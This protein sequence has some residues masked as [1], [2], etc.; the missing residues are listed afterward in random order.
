MQEADSRAAQG[1]RSSLEEMKNMASVSDPYIRG[2]LEKRREE[3]TAVIAT[4]TPAVPTAPYLDLLGEVD[5]AIHKMDQG[6]YGI[7]PV[8]HD[9][10]ER[11]RLIA[12]PLVTMC[13]DHLTA[14]DRRALEADLEL[15][16]RVQRGLLPEKHV[17]FGDWHVHYEYKAARMVSGDYCDLILPR[18][19]DGSLLF[20]L[21]DVAGKG[22]AASLLMTHMHAM[23]RSLSNG[24]SGEVLG[25]DKLLETANRVFCESTF[26]G[27]YATLVC[28]CAGGTGELELAS[29]GHLPALLVKRD[30]VRQIGATGLPLGMFCSSKYTVQRVRLDRGD[31]LLLFTDG[32][33]EARN[34]SGKEYGV[35]RLSS[36]AG[37][38]HRWVPQELLAAC[39]KD[40]EAHGAGARLA[41]DQTMMVVQ[42]EESTGN[43]VND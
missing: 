25:L 42:R 14:P 36:V 9:P 3:L 28:G 1:A 22:V 38:R 6:T 11:E 27:Q 12:D 26:A 33:S 15:A 13:L 17:R 4:A 29:A 31:S 23:F 16:A 32:I 43:S 24:G 2:Q 34:G 8:C 35:E 39:M 41:D 21:G 7:C 18:E 20:L 19:R 40:V 10:I 37:E 5:T 30:G